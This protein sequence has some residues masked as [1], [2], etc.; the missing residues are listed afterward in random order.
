[1]SWKSPG[2]SRRALLALALIL[3]AAPGH[4]DP[5][6]AAAGHDAVR[7]R[8]FDRALAI[9]QAGAADGDPEAMAGLGLLYDLGLGL[10]RDA[11]TA[12]RWY[13]M[14][15]A[16]GHADAQ[17][18]AGVMADSGAGVPKDPAH[19]AYWYARAAANGQPRAEMALGMLYA[20]G[21]GVPRNPALARIWL[22]RAAKR[23]PAA[24]ERLDALPDT[25]VDAPLTPPSLTAA[26]LVAD[27]SGTRRIEAAWTAGPAPPGTVYEFE[28]ATL[29][30]PARRSALETPASALVLPAAGLEGRPL[31]ARVLA[32]DRAGGRYAASLWHAVGGAAGE[33]LAPPAGRVLIAYEPG[34]IVAE[35]Y[36]SE[37]ADSLDGSDLLVETAARATATD[38]TR[39]LYRYAEDAALARG[40]ARALS[41]APAVETAPAGSSLAPGDILVEVVGGPA[42]HAGR[43]SRAAAR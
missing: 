25:G 40:V 24:A 19:A 2:A 5:T 20:T 1:M 6:A 43:I 18:N 32:V 42:G 30:G 12:F 4:A 29:D 26:D 7:A 8:D 35:T 9:W 33:G 10:P 31:A 27:Q 17:F 34:D 39:V 3:A 11:E 21:T 13:A 38:A 23:I 14:A 22:T 28:V 36:A 15:G 41:G 37:I 16:E